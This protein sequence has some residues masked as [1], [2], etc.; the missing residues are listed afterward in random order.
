MATIDQ[1]IDTIEKATDGISSAMPDIQKVAFENIVDLLKSLETRSGKLVASTGNLKTLQ[2]LN[3]EFS[4]AILSDEYADAVS[5]FTRSFTEVTNLQSKVFSET[6]EGFKKIP[7]VGELKRQAVRATVNS[8]EG[9]GLQSQ[10]VSKLDNLVRQNIVEKQ[11]FSKLVSEV[12]DFMEGSGDKV[13]AL[14]S[15]ASQI[16][17]DALN[18]YSASYNK[19]VTDDLGL[20]WYE[21]VGGLVR[22]SRPFCQALIQ[23]QFVHQS[24][25][26]AVANGNFEPTPGSLA[27]QIPGTN[28]SNLQIRR[29]GYNCQHLLIPI[30]SFRV[31]IELR[32]KFK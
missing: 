19:L 11:S 32:N 18:Q 26:N 22:D 13:G 1:L 21:Y 24:E 7:A 8:L 20:E 9:Q 5:E 27:G 12:Q 15:H 3:K 25:L 28:G 29:G 17:T 16:T 6:L 31:P 2:K 30:S 10:V 23:K 14:R 4:R